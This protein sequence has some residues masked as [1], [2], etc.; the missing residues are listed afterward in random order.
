MKTIKGVARFFGRDSAIWSEAT[1]SASCFANEAV[2]GHN[3]LGGFGDK[4]P[5]KLPGFYVNF[6]PGEHL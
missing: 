1:G 5:G 6:R 3:P 2:R 4:A